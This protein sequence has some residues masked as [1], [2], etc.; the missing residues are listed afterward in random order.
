MLFTITSSLQTRTRW[1]DVG[2]ML[3]VDY[4]I[5]CRTGLHCAPLAHRQMKTEEIHGT[6]RFGLGPFNTDEQIDVAINA[7]KEIAKIKKQSCIKI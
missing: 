6:V 1:G 3:D 5:A 7:V 4:D 2:T